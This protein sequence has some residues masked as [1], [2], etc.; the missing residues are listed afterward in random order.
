MSDTQFLQCRCKMCNAAGG[1]LVLGAI[2]L[3]DL[4]WIGCL[5]ISV[6]IVK[7]ENLYFD[8][9]GRNRCWR[10]NVRRA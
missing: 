3:G 4:D 10:C 1:D 8:G 6:K 9:C 2:G 5:Q 7:C